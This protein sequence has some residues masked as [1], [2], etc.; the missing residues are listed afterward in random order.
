LGI[1]IR[2][3]GSDVKLV[4]R[5]GLLEGRRRQIGFSEVK[6]GAEIIISLRQNIRSEKFE[7]AD[8]QDSLRVK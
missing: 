5:A 4:K 1:H 2:I 8:Q 6:T 3:Q 7:S